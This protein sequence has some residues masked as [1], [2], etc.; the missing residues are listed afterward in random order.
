MSK[1]KQE[2]PNFVRDGVAEHFSNIQL[3][4]R[5]VEHYLLRPRIRNR[6]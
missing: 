3:Q 4:H 1:T 6:C 2:M 5:S